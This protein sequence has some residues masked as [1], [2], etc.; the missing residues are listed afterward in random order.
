MYFQYWRLSQ[1]RLQIPSYSG[2]SYHTDG[3]SPH[4]FHRIQNLDTSGSLLIHLITDACSSNNQV[5]VAR[6]GVKSST[7]LLRPGARVDDPQ[8]A[9]SDVTAI[10]R[11]SFIQPTLSE[12]GPTSS[13]TRLY[14]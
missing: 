12:G 7:I 13:S 10:I 2:H 3:C 5:S 8:Q 14:H 6:G 1:L 4:G 9:R 11:V